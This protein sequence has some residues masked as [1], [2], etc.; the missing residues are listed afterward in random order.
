MSNCGCKVMCY[1]VV[2][3]VVY[4]GQQQAKT[5]SQK[6][7]ELTKRVFISKAS[8]QTEFATGSTE[9]PKVSLKNPETNLESK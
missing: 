3:D 8:E 4:Q 6:N 5:I 7:S 2:R 9:H 1:P